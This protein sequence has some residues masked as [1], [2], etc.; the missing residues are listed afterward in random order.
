MAC[1]YHIYSTE[2]PTGE[3]YIGQT[4]VPVNVRD[5]YDRTLMHFSG[6]Y[7]ERNQERE[8]EMFHAFLL[9]HPLSTMVM[10]IYDESNFFGLSKEIFKEFFSEWSIDG[11]TPYLDID[12]WDIDS[13][14]KLS[15]SDQGKKDFATTLYLDAAEIIHNYIYYKN[16][17]K[18][19]THQMGGQRHVFRSVTGLV[20]NDTLSPQQAAIMLEDSTRT[21]VKLQD[22]FNKMLEKQY[23]TVTINGK[24][25]LQ[26]WTETAWVMDKKNIYWKTLVNVAAPYL[27]KYIATIRD[28]LDK[29]LP[30]TG[31]WVLVNKM[32]NAYSLIEDKFRLNFA[33]T[34]KGGFNIVHA[35]ATKLNTDT[36]RS[37]VNKLVKQDTDPNPIKIY[38]A[39]YQA[40]EDTFADGLSGF[41]DGI[42]FANFYE[43]Q[44]KGTNVNKRNWR[45]SGPS[46]HHIA[47]SNTDPYGL[48][49][50]N[51]AYSFFSRCVKNVMSSPF[52]CSLKQRVMNDGQLYLIVETKRLSDE[53]YNYYARYVPIYWIQ[54]QWKMYLHQMLTI[55][56]RNNGTTFEESPFKSLEFISIN[57]YSTGVGVV[58]KELKIASNTSTS[59]LDLG[60]DINDEQQVGFPIYK[61]SD[62][63]W[64]D[65]TI[66]WESKIRDIVFF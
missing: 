9:K 12:V 23:K 49:L 48:T 28:D 8:N 17:Y 1:I 61:F 59:S 47:A 22:K 52:V 11:Y 40:I 29:I 14:S 5:S 34:T 32:K 57:N 13:T 45:L 16:G 65:M 43:L 7:G 51:M 10:D 58:N 15:Q 46:E 30:A 35:I 56:T 3:I 26:A 19:M 50:R 55:Y 63:T 39:I 25:L 53:L 44:Y 20:L 33:S 27:Q 38:H 18:L 60:D 4:K 37:K 2:D 54:Q 41:I 21:V 42:S 66:F 31:E 6:L 36:F 24:T 64:T 62:E